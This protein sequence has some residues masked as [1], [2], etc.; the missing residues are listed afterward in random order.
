M[1]NLQDSRKLVSEVLP[2]AS[3]PKVS[4]EPL[5]FGNNNVHPTRKALVGT[6][7]RK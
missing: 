6:V 4:L 2:R 5:Y 7:N 1:L 3:F